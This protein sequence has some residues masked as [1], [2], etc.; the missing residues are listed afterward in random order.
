MH[1]TQV[2]VPP[3]LLTTHCFADDQPRAFDLRI[4]ESRLWYCLHP[5]CRL[6]TSQLLEP[7][8]VALWT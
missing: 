3:W 1:Q 2:V 4:S 5:W 7:D 6:D 8:R